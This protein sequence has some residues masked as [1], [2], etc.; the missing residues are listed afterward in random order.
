MKVLSMII[1]QSIIL[2]KTFFDLIQHKFGQ[3][4]KSKNSTQRFNRLRN[5]L[6]FRRGKI[7][8]LHSITYTCIV[9][10]SREFNKKTKLN[11]FPR[12]PY[13][14]CFAIYLD[15][16]FNNHLAKLCC[17]IWRAGN[18]CTIVSRSGYI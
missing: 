9:L 5:A 18:N 7:F 8:Q 15:F 10:F 11:S 2:K 14:K 3:R 6:F 13:N 12:G 4:A 16:P 1:H 17:F